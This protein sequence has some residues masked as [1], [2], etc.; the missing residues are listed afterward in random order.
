MTPTA[1][2]AAIEVVAAVVRRADRV[3]FTRRPPGGPLG[4][5]W[6]FPGGKLEVGESASEALTREL[7]EELGVEARALRLLSRDRHTYAHGVSV[8]LHFL[9]AEIVAGELSPSAAVA[10]IAWW[11]P[12][13][14]D[15]SLVLEG[16]HRFVRQLAEELR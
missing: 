12:D 7:R 16:D 8:E 14:V 3:L 2:R 4:G 15:L 11:R 6:E 13:Q 10:E 5:L 9:E 1:P